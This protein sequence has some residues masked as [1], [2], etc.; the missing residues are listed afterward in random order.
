MEIRIYLQRNEYFLICIGWESEMHTSMY[1]IS[2][3]KV[4]EN[5]LGEVE[6]AKKVFYLFKK[7]TTERSYP[8][9]WN[10]FKAYYS[11]KT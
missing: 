4:W 1:F 3:E 5:L 2:I 6:F 11:H 9:Y 8:K 10:I 7:C